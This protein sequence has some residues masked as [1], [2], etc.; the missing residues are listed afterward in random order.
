MKIKS[1]AKEKSLIPTD[2]SIKALFRTDK[3][4]A[5]VSSSRISSGTKASGKT[6]TKKAKA[7]MK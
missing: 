2:H 5:M 1:M 3:G 7:V 4:T 6:T